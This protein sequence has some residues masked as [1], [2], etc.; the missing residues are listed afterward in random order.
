[1]LLKR[2]ARHLRQPT[3]QPTRPRPGTGLAGR[4]WRERDMYA[5]VLPGFLFFVVFAYLP[6]LGNIAAFQ[7]Y[8]PFLGFG[9]STWVGLDNFAAMFTDP[10]VWDALRNTLVISVLQIVF[11]F[12]APIALA[13]LLNS[14]ISER[15]KRIMQT[16][17]YLPHFL[18]W[19]IVIAIWQ[20]VVGGAG[21]LADLLAKLGAGHVNVMANPDTFPI[22]VTSQVIWKDVGWGTVIF[23]AAISAIPPELYESAAADGA[24]AWRRIWHIT[25]PGLI[26]VT[27][28]LLILRLGSV[29]T[30]GFEQILLQQP[31]VGAE[32][33]QV[34]D[35]FVYFR[36][37]V[38]GDWGLATAAGLLK[39][40]VGTVLIVAANRLAK[41]SGA[42]GLF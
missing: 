1:M 34:L 33:S 39:G 11:A 25:L 29:L 10:A 22:L 5:F 14:L 15:V 16:I 18:S 7:D 36:G 9:G 20:A 35:T 19:V 37:V 2:S 40:I 32:A 17:V 23:F 13:L 38:G 3:Q 4:M 21:P 26:P 42:E 41:R 31:A 8:S 12:P 30:V 24:G 6:L 28:L 27:L